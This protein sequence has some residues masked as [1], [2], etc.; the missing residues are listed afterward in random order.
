MNWSYYTLPLYILFVLLKIGNYLVEKVQEIKVKIS[1]SQYDREA[2]EQTRNITKYKVRQ[3]DITGTNTILYLKM[4]LD[5][6]LA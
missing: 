6:E 2:K 4:V 3:G 1:N 5:D